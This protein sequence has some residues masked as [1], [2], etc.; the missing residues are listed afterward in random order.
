MGWKG[1]KKMK[2]RAETHLWWC[3]GALLGFTLSSPWL[4]A[5][6]SLAAAAP[7]PPAHQAASACP[8]LPP[9]PGN[10]VNVSTESE[11]WTAVNTAQAG[12]TILLTDGTYNLGQ[13][14]HYLWLDTPDVTLGSASGNRAAVILDDNYSRTE[15]VTI[16][17]SN[18]T[19]ADLTLKRAGTHPIHVTTGSGDTLNTLI[20]NVHLIDPA[21]QAIKINPNPG[22]Y[23]PDNGVIACS[24]LE[25]TDAGRSQVDNDPIPCYTGGVDAHQARGWTIRDNVIEGFWCPAGLSEH[26]IHLWR[27]C[28]DTTVERNVL[29]NNA[30]GI[31]FGLVTSGSGRTYPDN[32]CPGASGYVDDFGG[33]I[34]NNFVF[35]NSAALFA[36]DADF[37]S[38]IAI[39]NSCNTR[40]LHNTVAS[41]QTP[42]ASS[43][44]WR[45]DNTDVTLLNN[46]V[47]YRLWDRGGTSSLAGNLEYQPLSLF[48]DG[49][50]GDLHLAS[51]ATDAIEQVTA[52]VD[53]SD[54]ID[55]D[56]RPIG[57][58]SDIGA[59]EYG[60]PP[61]AAVTDLRV[62]TALTGSG[63]LTATLNWTAPTDVLTVTLRYSYSPITAAN[64][65]GATLLTDAL[66]G[67]IETYLATVPYGG[68]PVYFAHKSRNDGGES[69]LS[70]NAFWP[71]LDTYLPLI[72]KG[73]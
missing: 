45:F 7:S 40:V 53:V 63:T 11:L 33:V 66:S 24:H 39:W 28:R 61:P 16:A 51:T 57:P 14:G 68:V 32:P 31:G 38:G 29:N 36:S 30:R 27:G 25:L 2:T 12:D 64:W 46:L 52:P 9:P 26:G 73:K 17:A 20:Y 49:A 65:T 43:I 44:E 58:G 19:I 71:Y 22:G 54:D 69:A 56:S 37:D 21:Q 34:R 10:I 13:N 55:G 3:L 62:T 72:L 70:N 1:T 41:T 18:V 60:L 6:P 35:A 15:I 67:S 50:N 48:A 42:A 23:Y 5:L 4:M 8:P 59:D 47:T